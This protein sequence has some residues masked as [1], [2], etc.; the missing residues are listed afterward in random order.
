MLP[1]RDC[2][3]FR[4]RYINALNRAVRSLTPIAGRGIRLRQSA[5]G[6]VIE[7]TAKGGGVGGGTPF[8][9]RW[10]V[11]HVA[12]TA[13]DGTT[14]H[15]LKV[16][17]GTLWRNDGQGVVNCLVQPDGTTVKNDG[18]IGWLVENATTGQLYVVDG[19]A[20]T[21]GTRFILCFGDAEGESR[22]VVLRV[23]DFF[24]GS[25]GVE[26]TQ[27]QVGDALYSAGGSGLQLG[28]WER[29]DER[30][31]RKLGTYS[32]NASGAWIF[33]P[34]TDAAGVELAPVETTE[35]M[36][37]LFRRNDSIYVA[38]APDIT[39]NAAQWLTRKTVTLDDAT[40]TPPTSLDGHG[41]ITST[42][43]TL[44]FWSSAEPSRGEPQTLLE[45]VVEDANATTTYE[46]QD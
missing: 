18:T 36:E 5:Q 46:E 23:A 4:S 1:L 33:T 7:A 41:A 13:D 24:V 38:D 29:D 26:L 20:E 8:G 28:P 22:A 2:R 11:T 37:V 6:V 15:K 3:G 32:R 12:E 45:T 27:R 19:G 43:T 31:V 14:T 10:K 44:T 40:F 16:A 17:F 25:S 39:D 35:N 34:A 30:W 42:P 21:T 9:H